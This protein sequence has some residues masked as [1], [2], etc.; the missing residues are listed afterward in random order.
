MKSTSLLAA[1]LALV[2]GAGQAFADYEKGSIILRMGA[3]LV[4]PDDDSNWLRLDGTQLPDTRLYVDD[5]ESA[6]ITGTW[7]FADHWGLGLLAAFPFNHDLKVSGLPDPAGGT[8]LGRIN[9]GDTDQLPPTL[10]VQ[11]FPV[12]VESWVQPYVGLGINYTTF[13]DENISRTA[14]DYFMM[15]LGAQAGAHLKLDDSWGL[16]GELGID[17]ALGRESRWLV[18]AAVWYLDLDTEAR[19]RFPTNFG[20]TV[21]KTD[22]DFDPWVYSVGIGYRF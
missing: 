14:N 13:M 17:I 4:D 12:C 11:W 9:L 2:L 20:R 3:G 19:I 18:N 22:I 10:T 7:L 6:T 21:I 8:P 15:V 1:A 5:G 16:A